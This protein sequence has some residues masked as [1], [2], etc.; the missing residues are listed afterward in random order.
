[1]LGVVVTAA[2]CLWKVIQTILLGPLNE[3]WADLPDMTRGEIITLAP[4]LV[5]MVLF[6]IFP[7]PILDLINSATVTLL[8]HIS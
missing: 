6:G 4:L 7:R 3:R 8:R 1:V 5:I 2:F